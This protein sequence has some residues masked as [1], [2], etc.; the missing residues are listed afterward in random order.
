MN[1][2]GTFMTYT[3]TK[4]HIF[5]AR[6]NSK[7]SSYKVKEKPFWKLVKTPLQNGQLKLIGDSEKKKKLCSNFGYVRID[8]ISWFYA[9]PRNICTMTRNDLASITT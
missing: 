5:I 6:V 8:N 1:I 3:K 2:V 9:T 4:V 7:V